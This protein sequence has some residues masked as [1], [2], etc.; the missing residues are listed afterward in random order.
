MTRTMQFLRQM[1]NVSCVHAG[2][3]TQPGDAT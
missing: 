1:F 2:R 3:R